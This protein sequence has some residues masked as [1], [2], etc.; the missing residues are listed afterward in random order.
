MKNADGNK[1]GDLCWDSDNAFLTFNGKGGELV[2]AGTDT[3]KL[4]KDDGTVIKRLRNTELANGDN[5]GEYWR[6][7]TP[8]GTKYYFGY[9]RPSGWADGKDETNSNWTVP[10]FGDDSGERVSRL[11]VRGLL[12]PAD[13]A[14]EP[15]CRRRPARQPDDVLLRQGDQLLRPQPDR[16]RRHLL[17]PRRLP[18]AESNTACAPSTTSRWPR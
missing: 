4:K 18:Q 13:L 7:T 15:R 11:R 2:P 6:L 16:V 17:R 10:V 5:D 3:F 8:D 14:L 12:V 9:N 1:P